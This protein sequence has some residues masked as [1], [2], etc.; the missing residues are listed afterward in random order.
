MERKKAI[1][2]PGV[3]FTDIL[4]YCWYYGDKDGNR[5]NFSGIPHIN[6]T[7][8]VIINSVYYDKKGLEQVKNGLRK[9]GKKQINFAYSGARSERIN[10]PYKI[11]F[12]ATEYVIY[13]LA[14]ICPIMSATLKR[15]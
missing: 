3:Y 10:I 6:D 12:I 13:D 9:P 5:V 4:D 15:V 11:K 14:Q 8:A 7:F 1:N 2:E